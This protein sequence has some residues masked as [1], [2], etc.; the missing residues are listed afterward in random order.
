MRFDHSSRLADKTVLRELEDGLWLA[1][2]HLLARDEDGVD[3]YQQIPESTDVEA[4]RYGERREP[5][6]T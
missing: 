2:Q 3:W 6:A 5:M 1:E 4:T